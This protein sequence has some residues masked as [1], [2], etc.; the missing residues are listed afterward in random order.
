MD[1]VKDIDHDEIRSGFLVKSDRKKLWNVELGCYNELR[2]VCEKY[3]IRFF[4]SYGTLL[5]AIR[6]R[7]FIPWDDDMDFSMFRPDYERFKEAARKEIHYP[8]YLDIWYENEDIE[9]Y[10]TTTTAG[11]LIRIHDE[12][13][14]AIYPSMKK[15]EKHHQGILIDIFPMDSAPPPLLITM[16]QTNGK[17]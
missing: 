14:T 11:A 17:R 1:F 6:H 5:G 7:G 12:R 2:R 3:D 13:T 9:E 15:S 10:A 8:Y 4:A 16:I